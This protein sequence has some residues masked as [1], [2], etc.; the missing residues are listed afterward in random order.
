MSVGFP[1]ILTE[2][3]RGF[4][5]TYRNIDHDYIPPNPYTPHFIESYVTPELKVLSVTQLMSPHSLK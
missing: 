1:A 2:L 4:L 5:R 3:S